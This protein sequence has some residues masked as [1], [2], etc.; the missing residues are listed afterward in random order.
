MEF[1]LN[2]FHIFFRSIALAMPILLFF[3]ILITLLGFWIGRKEGWS[4]T[5]S[6]YYAFVTATTLG[7]GDMTPK[8]KFTK[9]ISIFLTFC[10]MIF[11]GVVVAI[12]VNSISLAYQVEK[13]GPL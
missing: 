12:A 13:T 7:Y 2:F 5:D 9:Y 3:F 6:F 1:T 10:G 11:T 8:R 4:R